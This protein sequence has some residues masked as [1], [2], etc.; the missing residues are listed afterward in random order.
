MTSDYEFGNYE[1]INVT[2]SYFKYRRRTMGHVGKGSSADGG[3]SS[4]ALAT[5]MVLVPVRVI[6][7]VF[8]LAHLSY[9]PHKQMCSLLVRK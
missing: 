7:S 8:I 6:H 3:G 9:T 4:Q 1:T 5:G 2:S